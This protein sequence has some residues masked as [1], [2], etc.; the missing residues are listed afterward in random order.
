M[1]GREFLGR[2]KAKADC[3][4][5]DAKKKAKEALKKLKDRFKF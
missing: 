5:N 4:K 1:G 2:G 3:L